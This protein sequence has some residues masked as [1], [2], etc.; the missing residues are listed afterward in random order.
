M[1]NLL[2][3]T[4]A[5]MRIALLVSLPAMFGIARCNSPYDPRHASD[6]AVAIHPERDAARWT[7]DERGI[8]PLRAGLAIPAI[9]QFL[10]GV[11]GIPAGEEMSPCSY[12]DW[13]G[14]PAGVYVLLERGVI[15]RVEVDSAGTATAAGARVGD[16]EA[17]IDS[18]YAGRVEREGHKFTDGRY[19]VVRE[20]AGAGDYRIVFETDGE[21]VMRYRAG[22]H[23]A[24]SYDD[25]CAGDA[26]VV[27]EE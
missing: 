4:L 16:T 8:G 3:T 25:A 26:E 20:A 5:R 14:A 23:P 10:P 13:P 18:L 19:L 12:A 6:D 17:R 2:D 24:V 21:R 27:D 11:I 7:V 15:T 9:G 22:I 1:K